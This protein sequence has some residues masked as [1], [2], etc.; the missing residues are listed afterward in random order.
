MENASKQMDTAIITERLDMIPSI[1]AR[2][3][4]GYISD[5][6]F[7]NDFYFQFGWPYS[8]ELLNAID[9]HSS[10]VVYYSIF[11]KDTWTMVGYV[12]I[13]PYEDDSTYGEIEFYI[14]H[15]FRRQ[16]FC[17]EALTAFIDSF[18]TGFL[19]GVKGKHVVAETLSDNEPVSKLLKSMGFT[20]EAWGMRCSFNEEGEINPSNSIGLHVYGLYAEI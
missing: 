14:F 4:D 8:D 6:L 11:L 5:L 2:D 7:T 12:G 17:K 9:F 18:F 13:L 15:N 10:G 1:D 20:K 3:L 16:G 19:I